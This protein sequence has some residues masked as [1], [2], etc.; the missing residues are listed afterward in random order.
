MSR[1]EK[2]ITFVGQTAKVACDGNC[3]KAWGG[4]E[5]PRVQLSNNVDDFAWLADGE[6]GE[7]P[8]D[9]GTYEGIDMEGKPTRVTGPDDLN[10]WCVREC[11]RMSMS[12]PGTW[13]QPLPV[14]DFSQRLYNI[15]SSDPARWS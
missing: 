15:P 12:S 5:R 10:R 7:A 4:S 8:R 11:E 3:S 9:P 1:I 14:R 2:L 6:L 13:R